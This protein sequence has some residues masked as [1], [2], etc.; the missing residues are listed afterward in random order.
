MDKSRFTAR[1]EKLRRLMAREGLDVLLVSHPA[2]RYYLSG[3][4][5]YDGQC[6]ESSGCLIVTKD[7]K[8][9]L[10]TD[11]RYEVA[12]ALLWPRERILIYKGASAPEVGG[13]L[14]H[15]A[16]GP[17]G[18][19]AKILSWDYVWHLESGLELQ[20]ADG[21]VEELRVI[22]DEDEIALI[23][24]SVR[25]N[26]DMMTWLPSILS[27]G[28]NEAEIAWGL[29]K[30]FRE[31]G[32]SGNSF[33]PIVAKN[34]NAALPHYQPE[35]N[36]ELITPNCHILVDAGARLDHY[37]S[38]QTR[39]FWVGDKPSDRFLRV[40][41]M[42][43]EAQRAA[44]SVLRPGLTGR[45]A[46]QAAV[47]YFAAKGMDKHFNHSLGHGVGLEVHE[48]P[49]LSPRSATVLQPGMIVTV[50][51]GLYFPE[52][53]GVRWEYMVAITEDGCRVL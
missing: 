19:E 17:I 1:R 45:Q 29:E 32:A 3:F 4:E 25:L 24:R 48:E 35:S 39:T 50:E 9:W 49:R 6:N 27:T 15:L 5:L 40:L 18:F 2:N 36:S 53:G 43:R 42:V 23:E 52:W 21:L 41:N 31:H 22:K 10:C 38:D 16:H 44:I 13:Q 46:H 37:C 34:S 12:A 28:I 7:G 47:D 11:S 30:Y 8:D 14:R 26:H 51:P 33:P 20:A